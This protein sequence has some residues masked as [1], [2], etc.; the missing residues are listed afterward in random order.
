LG[1]GVKLGKLFITILLF[2]VM[3][4][5]IFHLNGA[6]QPVAKGTPSPSWWEAFC[7]CLEFFLSI[8]IPS[9]AAWTVSPNNSPIGI[10]FT[11][12]ATLLKLSG[13]IFGILI[14]AALAGLLKRWDLHLNGDK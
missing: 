13:L 6:V 7:I 4:T 3:G 5:I 8:E 9:A 1:Y 10:K 12:F 14:V 11:T 2:I